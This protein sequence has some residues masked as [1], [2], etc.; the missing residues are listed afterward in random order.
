MRINSAVTLPDDAVTIETT[1]DCSIQKLEIGTGAPDKARL[2]F[3]GTG[4]LTVEQQMNISGGD[5]NILTVA[6]GASVIAE[7]GI[8]IGASGGTNSTVTVYGTLTAKSTGDPSFP[9][10]SAGT[11]VVGGGG[12]LEV[13]GKQGVQLNGMLSGSSYNV[14]GVFT[15]Q[16]DGCFKADAWRCILPGQQSGP[17]IPYSGRISARRLQGE[18]GDRCGQPCEEKHR[19]RVHRTFDHR[20]KQPFAG[21]FR[22]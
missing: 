7:G 20:Q 1:G 21:R 13:S 14:A 22:S 3:T 17:G 9:A 15:V 11:V 8:S 16:E 19:S 4:T 12:L 6:A 2:N 10:I 5:G 18:V